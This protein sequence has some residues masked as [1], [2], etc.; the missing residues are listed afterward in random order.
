MKEEEGRDNKNLWWFKLNRASTFL[1]LTTIT[2]LSINVVPRNVIYFFYPYLHTKWCHTS[3]PIL[4][5]LPKYNIS[6]VRLASPTNQSPSIYAHTAPFFLQFLVHHPAQYLLLHRH[7]TIIFRSC[8]VILS[9]LLPTYN[10]I[11]RFTAS[12]NTTVLFTI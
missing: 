8:T 9:L 10:E 5:H 6:T 11:H 7:G 2:Y 3:L 4:L 12:N 1:C